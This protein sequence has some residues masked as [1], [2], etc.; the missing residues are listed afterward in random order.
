MN[1]LHI[2]DFH[3]SKETSLQ[4]NVINAIINTISELEKSIDFVWYVIVRDD[5]VDE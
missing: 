2:T 3:F 4:V 1:I 5:M